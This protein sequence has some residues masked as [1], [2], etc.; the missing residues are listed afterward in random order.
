MADLFEVSLGLSITDDNDTEVFNL[1]SSNGAPGLS[2]DEIAAPVGSTAVD[3]L[4]GNLYTKKTAGSGL[5]KWVRSAN[6]DDVTAAVNGLSWKEPAKVSDPTVYADLTAAETALNTGSLDGVALVDQDRVL[7]PN[8]TTGTEGLYTV[9]GTPGAGATLVL[10]E[11]PVD[12]DTVYIQEGTTDGDKTY[13]FNGTDWVETG[14]GS[15]AELAFIRAFIGKALSGSVLPDYTSNNYILDND[16]LTAAISKLDTQI[17][18][19]ASNIS[20]NTGNITNVQTEVDLL[21]T[22]LGS[23]INADGT[24]NGFTGTGLLDST[25]SITDALEALDAVVAANSD[26]AF[27]RAFIGKN[28]AGSELPAYS[29]NN[30]VTDN[31]DLETAIGKLDTYIDR[32]RREILIA[33]NIAEN[34]ADSVLVDDV[35]AVEW[36]IHAQET[37]TQDTRVVFVHG[38]HN[39]NTGSDANATDRAEYARL[40]MGDVNGFRTRVVLNGAG[41]S[42]TMQLLVRT[43]NSS[44]LT[45]TRKI[46]A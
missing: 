39:G 12:A 34:I 29:S 38:S 11:T 3:Q 30:I 28:A 2:L 21:E 43:N 4:T 18:T 10:V 45:I 42:Q 17:G 32:E 41:V 7:L 44:D 8:L 25:T 46:L 37:A 31:D 26:D 20:A 27:I 9:S 13:S 36:H 22:S 1:L 24:F 5:D 23:A 15:A 19:N 40:R 16:S 14:S 6:V 35:K 33:G